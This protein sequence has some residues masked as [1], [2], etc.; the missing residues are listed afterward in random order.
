MN[1]WRLAAFGRVNRPEDGAPGAGL[2]RNEVNRG[3]ASSQNTSEL[4]HVYR[5]VPCTSK[6]V[7]QSPHLSGDSG[8]ANTG[9]LCLPP[10]IKFGPGQELICA[11]PE[12]HCQ[13]VVQARRSFRKTHSMT[14]S[15]GGQ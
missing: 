4:V 6:S 12:Q 3:T 8:L 15:V 5:R 2:R 11:I 13:P 7:K 14:Y 10:P 1:S 9:E